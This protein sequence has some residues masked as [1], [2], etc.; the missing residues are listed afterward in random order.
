MHKL[1]IAMT[2]VF[3]AALCSVAFAA[4]GPVV[5]MPGQEHWAAQPGNFSMAVLY[6]DPSKSDFYVVRLKLPANWTFPVH[7]HPARENVTVIS[8]TLYAGLGTKMDK[9]K[10]AAYPAGSF[11]SLPAKLPHFAF[12]KSQ[13][14]VI[15]L[16]GTGPM[17]N[18]MMKK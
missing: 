12:T 11:I 6:G 2:F 7:Y 18:T 14:T 15:Q 16:E 3:A 1:R 13:P 8:G 5:V 10:A 9:S 4:S 17:E